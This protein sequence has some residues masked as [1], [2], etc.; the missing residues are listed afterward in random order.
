MLFNDAVS[1]VEVIQH[2]LIMLGELEG[3][4]EAM[5]SLKV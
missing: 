1:T 5:A 3:I 2:Q 4:G